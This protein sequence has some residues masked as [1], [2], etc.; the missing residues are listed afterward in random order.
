MPW[1]QKDTIKNNIYILFFK[2]YDKE[3][4]KQVLC[5]CQLNYD[6]ANLE[7]KD[8]TEIGEGVNLLIYQMAKRSEFPWQERCIPT[9]IYIF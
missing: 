7:G 6:L 3:K 9:L 4:Y 2:K 1:I 8:L 5:K